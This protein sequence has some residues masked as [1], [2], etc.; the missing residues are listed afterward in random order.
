VTVSWEYRRSGW[1]DSVDTA[2]HTLDKRNEEIDYTLLPHVHKRLLKPGSQTTDLT[3]GYPPLAL[4]HRT[5]PNPAPCSSLEPTRSSCFL[6]RD[7]PSWP[8]A[9]ALASYPKED[10]PV[11][12]PPLRLDGASRAFCAFPSAGC[13]LR[14]VP[15]F[16]WGRWL[17]V[18]EI[19][20]VLQRVPP[21]PALQTAIGSESCTATRHSDPYDFTVS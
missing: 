8:H 2:G 7:V 13:K 21:R 9:S 10:W 11:L 17:D 1:Q 14:G 4:D 20:K 6:Q 5:S 3:R 19:Q 15:C 18:V 12:V 16:P